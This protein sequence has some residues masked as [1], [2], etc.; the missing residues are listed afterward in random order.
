M[1]TL[2]GY[3]KEKFIE[4]RTDIRESRLQKAAMLILEETPGCLL[5]IGCG[6][7]SF[8]ARF[9]DSGYT[10]YGI[11]LT[12]DQ[13]E[14]ARRNGIIPLVHDLNSGHLPFDNSSFDIIFAGEVIEHLV[15]TSFFLREIYRVLRP[16]GCT[17]LTTPNL[18]SLENRLR[19][20]L[21]YYPMWLDYKLEGG[22]GHVRAYTSRTIKRHLREC[23]FDVERVL[24][25]WVPFL[26][27]GLIDDIRMP[28]LAVTGNWFPNLA[29][30]LI[31]KAR[32]PLL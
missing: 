22:Q 32:K 4:L 24:G 3:N 21:G 6:S 17:I 5:D 8:C 29:M 27:Q 26:P 2:S 11:D 23:S 16:G 13:I 7:G 12:L 19:L 20:L 18:A 14:T 15:D 10:V 30:D 1:K 31:V 9:T 25:N 28:L